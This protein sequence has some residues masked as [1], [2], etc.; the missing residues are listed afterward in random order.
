MIAVGKKAPD[1]TLPSTLGKNIGLKDFAGKKIVLYFYPKDNT[2]GCTKEACS[3]QDNLSSVT[4]LGAVVLGVSTDP[5]VSHE[6]F[7]SKY[8]LRFPLLSDSEKT[9]VEQYGVWKEKSLYGRKFMGIQRT[10]VLID[11]KRIIRHIFSNVKVD[12]HIADVLKFLKES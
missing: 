2:P 4:R 12:G 3:F 6:K 5:L 9:V 7:A 10:T 1:F 8:E 11:E